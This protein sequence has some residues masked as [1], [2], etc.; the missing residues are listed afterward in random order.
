MDSGILFDQLPLDVI[1]LMFD[2]PNDIEKLCQS[3]N[4]FYMKYC[5]N[6]NGVF[7]TRMLDTYF[8]IKPSGNKTVKE[9]YEIYRLEMPKV[10]KIY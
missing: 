3:S 4:S 6:P 5:H 8:H 9:Q 1:V 2:D 7:W 10:G